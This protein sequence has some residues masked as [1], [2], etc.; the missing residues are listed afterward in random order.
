MV[1]KNKEKRNKLFISFECETL[2]AENDA[3]DHIRRYLPNLI[4]CDAVVNIGTMKIRGLDFNSEEDQTGK[5][6][7]CIREVEKKKIDAELFIAGSATSC[8][9]EIDI[10]CRL[11][12]DHV[13]SS[14]KN[15][16]KHS[17]LLGSR[18]QEYNNPEEDMIRQLLVEELQTEGI[19][20]NILFNKWEDS[21]SGWR[22]RKQVSKC[23][24]E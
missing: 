7:V 6:H 1:E 17:S 4:G 12:D 15:E 2:K 22:I 21:S 19:A 8:Q 23:T 16:F 11:S 3:Q 5:N 24:E 13:P 14:S 20:A 10:K 18:K 9:S